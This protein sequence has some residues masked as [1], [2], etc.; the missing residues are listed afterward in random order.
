MKMYRTVCLLPTVALAVWLVGC[1]K[2]SNP[3]EDASKDPAYGENAVAQVTNVEVAAVEPV[4]EAIKEV[5]TNTVE[6][7]KAVVTPP[8]ESG[9]VRYNAQPGGSKAIVAGDSSIH[10][11]TMESGVIGG[12]M[13][14]DANFPESALSNPTA[15]KPVTSVYVPV[16]SIKSGKTTMDERMQDTMSMT[17]YQKI[18]YRVI[19]LKPKSQPGSTGA[20]QFD[21]VGT[22]TIV[23]KTITNTMPVSIEKK[24]GKLKVV[25][26]T[27][28]KL[29]Q[30]EIKPPVIS[31]LGVEA[32]SVYDDLKVDFE[33]TLA[34]KK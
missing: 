25:G 21:A 5:A 6:A 15:A 30:F 22:L 26:S 19:E 4:K 2:K 11:W 13:E 20:L 12:Y 18:E 17:N 8:V 3:A 10:A 32:I 16:R 23:G 14:V 33:W 27:P 24:D 28:L 9:L 1:N 7:V 34:P 29:T 31:L